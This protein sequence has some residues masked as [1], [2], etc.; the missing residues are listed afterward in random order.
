MKELGIKVAKTISVSVGVLLA[1]YAEEA[2]TLEEILEI[3]FY[4]EKSTIAMD[5]NY[6]GNFTR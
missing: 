1:A 6:S 3:A 2:I 4:I 5:E